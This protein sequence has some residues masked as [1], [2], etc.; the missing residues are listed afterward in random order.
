MNLI[1]SESNLGG[2]HFKHKG[3]NKHDGQKSQIV[4]HPL[5][6]RLP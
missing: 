1:T 4:E 3:P 2:S 6:E 5:H